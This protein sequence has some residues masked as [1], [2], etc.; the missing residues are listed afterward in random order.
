MCSLYKYFVR[1]KGIGGDDGDG[2]DDGGGAQVW[3]GVEVAQVLQKIYIYMLKYGKQG[4]CEEMVIT[5]LGKVLILLISG[6][7]SH[8]TPSDVLIKGVWRR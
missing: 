3:E 5:I 1:R 7:K 2:D 6:V 4:R 8:L